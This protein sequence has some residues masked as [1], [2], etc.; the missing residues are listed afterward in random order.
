MGIP[1]AA[2]SPNRTQQLPLF[3]CSLYNEM[4]TVWTPNDYSN[5]ITIGA[6][7][8]PIYRGGHMLPEV[9]ATTNYV[10]RVRS[11]IYS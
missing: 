6:V 3:I 4:S 7:E 2:I 8:I 11:E 1:R 9:L 5:I 10:L